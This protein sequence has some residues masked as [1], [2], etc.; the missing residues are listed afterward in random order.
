MQQDIWLDDSPNILP[1]RHISKSA[2]GLFV[3]RRFERGVPADQRLAVCQKKVTG[4][5]EGK[6]ES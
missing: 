6:A 4:R 5:H 1:P 2:G 3:V